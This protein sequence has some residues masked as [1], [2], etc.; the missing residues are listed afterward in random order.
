MCQANYIL[1]RN[2]LVEKLRFQLILQ[3]FKFTFHL[4]EFTE[5]K[6]NNNCVQNK[7]VSFNGQFNAPQKVSVKKQA[8]WLN[9]I[10]LPKIENRGN[11]F[12]SNYEYFNFAT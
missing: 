5:N 9:I 10:F 1:I 3:K 11:I 12:N 4:P 7:R 8:N 6:Q 2:Q